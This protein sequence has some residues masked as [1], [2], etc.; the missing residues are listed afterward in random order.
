MKHQDIEEILMIA[1]WYWSLKLKEWN[2]K[3]LL[4]ILFYIINYPI[5]EIY[6]SSYSE[7]FKC[8]FV[9]FQLDLLDL[10][11]DEEWYDKKYEERVNI[12]L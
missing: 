7:E 4:N 9:E 6:K 8:K 10:K 3:Q 12:I 1:K 2:N 5:E 11:W